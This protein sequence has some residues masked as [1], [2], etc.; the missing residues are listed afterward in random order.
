MKKFEDASNPVENILMIRCRRRLSLL[1]VLQSP[2]NTILP[3]V[4]DRDGGKK[5]LTDKQT[6]S[7]SPQDRMMRQLTAPVR[8][9]PCVDNASPMNMARKCVFQAY[10]VRIAK[11]TQM[12][13]EP[14]MQQW[15]A[16]EIERQVHSKEC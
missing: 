11:D 5:V 15:F 1:A 2:S 6:K 9:Q 10:L 13:Q 16:P 4:T 8:R 3:C 14:R 12:L 7:T